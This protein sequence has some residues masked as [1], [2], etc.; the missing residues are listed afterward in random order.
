MGLTFKLR[1]SQWKMIKDPTLDFG[2]GS[3][4]WPKFGTFIFRFIKSVGFHLLL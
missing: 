2:F 4:E 1:N 3:I